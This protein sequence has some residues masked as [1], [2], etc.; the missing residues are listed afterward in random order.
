[1]EQDHQNYVSPFSSRY[2]SKEMK[3]L[4][5]DEFKFTTFRRL[6]V[7]LAK[8]EKK[9]GLNITEE[10]IEELEAH[11]NTL[12]YED[13]EKKEAEIRHDV[14]AQI[15][16]YGLQCPKA[17]GIIHLGATS[18][19]VD[20]NTDAIIMKKAS[21]IVLAK[22]AQ[23]LYQ[24]KQFAKK[25]ENV[26]CL[27]YT[28]LQPAQLTTIGK[29][30]TLWMN[31]LL[32]NIHNLEYQLDSFMP[33]GCKGTTG[34]QAS[35]MDLFNGD[36]KKVRKLDEAIVKDMG[37]KKTI[38]VSGQ[39]Y[40]RI[41]DSYVMN[42]LAG[43]AA[44]C[45]KFSQDLRVLQSYREVE[46]PFEKMQV[47]SSAMPYKRNPMRAERM[48]GIARYVLLNSMNSAFNAS[49]QFFERTLDDSSNRRLTISECFLG[50]DSL[51][52]LYI[53]ITSGL[54]V[55]RKVIDHRVE[56]NL[57]F[58]AT[59]NIMME[60]VKRGKDR[61]V[62]HEKLRVYSQKAATDIKIGKPNL[63]LDWI[64]NDESFGLT[65]EEI[66]KIVNPKKFIGRSASQTEEF[67]QEEINPVLRKYHRKNI[68]EDL[69]V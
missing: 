31:E 61:Q 11:V 16:A 30:A 36:E 48:T 19:Y 40:T 10:Q 45:Y 14:M 54:V 2:A 15:Y 24:L 4:F 22:A 56:E 37:F 33:L 42:C 51:L 12:N 43:F 35:F 66:Q 59:E 29:R 57:P 32:I 65:K 6:W 23:V 9:L 67:I 49:S 39:T 5:S 28:H 60:A 20:D 52:N 13:A 69:K 25:Y 64:E 44:A 53:N 58:M 27:A 68:K 26:P 21:E 1:M 41:E 34:T 18:C 62:L 63:L 3:Y 47:G 50:I 7:I 55:N 8:E 17:K 46:E 38:P